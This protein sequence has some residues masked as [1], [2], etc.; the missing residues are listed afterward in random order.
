MKKYLSILAIL[1]LFP[2]VTQAA[3]RTLDIY[4]IDVEGGAATLIVTPFGESLLIDSGFPEDRDAQRI[5]Y[6]A[7]DVAGLSQI[8]HYITTHW[9]RDHV[10]GVTLLVE[11]DTVKNYYDHGLPTAPQPIFLG[12]DSAHIGLSRR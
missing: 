4:F 11:T 7:K 1:L 12:V 6:V 3:G 2:Q 8:D 10:G 5:L 9:H